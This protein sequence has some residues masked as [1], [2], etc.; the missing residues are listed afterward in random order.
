VLLF[1]VFVACEF[2]LSFSPCFYCNQQQDDFG[3][4][5]LKRCWLHQTFVFSL[6]LSSIV[7][8]LY[9]IVLYVD[10]RGK[11]FF[12]VVLLLLSCFSFFSILLVDE[13]A[14]E[15]YLIL[16]CIISTRRLCVFDCYDDRLVVLN[17]FGAVL[18]E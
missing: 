18:C 15:L 11:N 6:L 12:V 3:A 2:T 8:F 5:S 13:F 17:A 14:G 4:A 9:S 7:L 1:R 10:C 16:F